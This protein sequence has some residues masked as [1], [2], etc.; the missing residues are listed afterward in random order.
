M[1]TLNEAII[2]RKYI[3]KKIHSYSDTSD[4][5]DA[6]LTILNKSQTHLRLSWIKRTGATGHD[7]FS[8]PS[9]GWRLEVISEDWDV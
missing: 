2:G 7:E 6:I 9:D 4:W 1:I 5:N 3:L 8:F